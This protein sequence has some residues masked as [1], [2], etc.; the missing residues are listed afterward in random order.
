MDA[1]E[2]R[3]VVVVDQ[4]G[5]VFRRTW[6]LWDM[7]RSLGFWTVNP[8]GGMGGGEEGERV[9]GGLQAP[10]AYLFRRGGEEG[11]TGRVP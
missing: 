1:G 4:E 3:I 5:A 10:C 9:V 6:C 8:G 7:F 11:E 2:G